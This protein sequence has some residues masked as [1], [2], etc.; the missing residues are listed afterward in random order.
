M[1]RGITKN[2]I[3]EMQ[4]YKKMLGVKEIDQLRNEGVLKRPRG[5]TSLLRSVIEGRGVFIS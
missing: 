5:N 4:Y 3:F 1:N 2:W